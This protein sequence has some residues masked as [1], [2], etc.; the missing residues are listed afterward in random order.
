VVYTQSREAAQAVA[1]ELQLT[2]VRTEAMACD[3]GNPQAVSKAGLLDPAYQEQA[4]MGA[5]LRCAA[6]KDDIAEQV[7][8]FCRTDS[9]TGQTLAIDAERFFH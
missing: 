2:G 4:R 9:I 7:V 8:A 6:D 5:L 3:V 1:R